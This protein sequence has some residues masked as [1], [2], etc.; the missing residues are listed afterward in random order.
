MDT[1]SDELEDVPAAIAITVKEEFAINKCLKDSW[2]NEDYIMFQ[3]LQAGNIF[4]LMDSVFEIP[5]DKDDHI[6]NFLLNKGIIRDAEFESWLKN[7]Y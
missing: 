2:Y 6:E 4:E 1:S 7:S 5:E 3:G